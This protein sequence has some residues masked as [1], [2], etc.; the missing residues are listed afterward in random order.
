LEKQPPRHRDTY[1][2]HTEEHF[3]AKPLHHKTEGEVKAGD[4]LA[5]VGDTGV[6]KKNYHLHTERQNPLKTEAS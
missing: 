2:L 4:V 3:R 5:N 6:A 1:N